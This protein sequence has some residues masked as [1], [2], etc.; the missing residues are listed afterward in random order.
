MRSD[1]MALQPADGRQQ[2]LMPQTLDAINA[3]VD[4]RRQRT[5]AISPPVPPVMWIALV[6]G[7]AITVGFTFFF[8]Y[9]RLGPQLLMVSAMTALLAFT[10]WLTYEMSYP[11]SG[12]TGL[13]PD[14]FVEVLS[15]FKEFS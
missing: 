2:V 11:F 1:I 13:G 9:G 8:G 14:A 15:R 3:L 7:A 4:A 5:G 12:P 6:A 10:L